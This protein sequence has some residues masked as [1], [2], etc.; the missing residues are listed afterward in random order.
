M[1]PSYDICAR[2]VGSNVVCKMDDAVAHSQPRV[3]HG[4]LHRCI[5]YRILWAEISASRFRISYLA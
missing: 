3:Q 1:K 5:K 4:E 2:L